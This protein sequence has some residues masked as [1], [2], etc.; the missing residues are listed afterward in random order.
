MTLNM[1][2]NAE[3]IPDGGINM[4][5]ELLI[6][7]CSPTLAGLKSGSLFC[8]PFADREALLRQMRGY[9]TI[10]RKKGISV[11]PVRIGENR[12][13][14]YMCRPKKLKADLEKPLTKELLSAAGYKN[15]GIGTVFSV[16]LQKLR[17]ENAVF[18]HE[19]GLF[20]GYPPEDVRGFMQNKGRGCKLAGCWKV[21]GDENS[22]Q[23]TFALYKKCTR[24]YTAQYAAGKPLDRLAV[25]I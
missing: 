3:N 20:L 12:A 10:L 9:N 7:Q 8:M 1:P 14:I 2:K 11:F 18:P 22:A 16:L 23:R 4:S 25:K 13:L 6:R 24:L 19:I 21:Y 5:E 15:C 17:S